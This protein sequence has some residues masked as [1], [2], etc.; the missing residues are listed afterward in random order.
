MEDLNKEIGK[1]LTKVA[2]D[3]SLFNAQIA[4]YPI[5]IQPELLSN[6]RQIFREKFMAE[7]LAEFSSCYKDQ[8]L[9]GAVDACIDLMYVT[10]G[11]LGEM[12][13][14]VQ[15]TWA[16]VQRANM[17]KLRGERAKRPGA[18]GFDT[19][20]PEGWIGPSH[21]DYLSIT[22]QDIETI[23]EL[24]RGETR[25]VLAPKRPKL[26]IMG[27]ARHGKD[28]V[29]E[30]MRDKYGLSFTSSSMFCAEYAVWPEMPQYATAQDCFND[31]ANHR[32][33][34]HNVIKEFN[35]PDLTRI[36]RLIFEKHDL[37]CGIRSQQE[38]EALKAAKVFD[39]SIWVDAS[40]RLPT[41][42]KSSCDVTKHMTDFCLN[43]NGPLADL[44]E[45]VDWFMSFFWV[46]ALK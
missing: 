3:W 14:L 23:L 22:A 38:F 40:E 4:G 16:E 12:G 35:S 46:E 30:I 37:Y 15:P 7:E 2:E 28:T 19:Y 26:M 8:D 41:E 42:D 24:R 31:R 9:D 21:A 45:K 33:H 36:G 39:W 18:Q 44:E 43:N 13:V 34:W 6:T 32:A 10:I 17:R 25:L 27:Y 1:V 11:A 5:P 20:K 29:C